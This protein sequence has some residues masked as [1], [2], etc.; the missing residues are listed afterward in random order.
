MTDENNLLFDQELGYLPVKTSLVDDPY[1]QDPQR[2][3]F[4]DL[5]PNAIFP[6][7]FPS[8]DAVANE[9]LKVYN[10]VVVTGELTP[11]DAVIRAAEAAR[12]VI[13]Q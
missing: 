13:T 10:Q 12:S 6:P 7:A 3:P 8:F 11:E 4:V 2:K 5:L 9:M 1:F